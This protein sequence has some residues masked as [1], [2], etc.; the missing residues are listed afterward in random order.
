LAVGIPRVAP[1]DSAGD[2]AKAYAP[3]RGVA[4]AS[5]A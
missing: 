2:H 1:D 4:S 5:V 3:Y